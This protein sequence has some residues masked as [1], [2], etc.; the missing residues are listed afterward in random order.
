M[1]E[2]VAFP[3]IGRW[4]RDITITEKIDG[5][6]AA[7]VLVPLAECSDRAHAVT[8]V[9]DEYA[10][11]AQSRTR[12]I[13]P[14]NDNH[15]F[16]AWVAS[17]AELL[18][19]LGAGQHFGEWWGSGI[20]RGYGVQKGLKYF[21]LFNVGRWTFPGDPDRGDREEIPS[22]P[23]LDVVPV[24]YRGPLDLKGV[25]VRYAPTANP[26]QDVLA[27]LRFAGSVAAPGFSDPEGIMIWH[28]SIRT[29]SKATLDGDGH[30]S[31]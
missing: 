10:V 17:N 27:K 16:A 21:S 6:N 15:G 28:E 19:R 2:F 25:S 9:R 20:Q 22:V 23:G 1:T 31:R 13:Q 18:S 26:V 11:F 30:K 8:V 7:I 14:G 24:L 12:F 4:F 29:Y 3:K 5:T